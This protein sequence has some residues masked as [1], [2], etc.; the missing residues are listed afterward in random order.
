MCK[1][2]LQLHLR[3]EKILFMMHRI[4]FGLQTKCKIVNAAMIVPVI[5]LQE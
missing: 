3:V 5:I 2:L 1:G 4:F